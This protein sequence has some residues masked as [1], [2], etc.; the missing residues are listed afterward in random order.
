MEGISVD[1]Q[2]EATKTDKWMKDAFRW[3]R[4][5]RPSIFT[6]L[7]AYNEWIG[8]TLKQFE[9]LEKAR[10]ISKS[11]GC[12]RTAINT[13]LMMNVYFLCCIVHHII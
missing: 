5:E 11:D 7:T 10:R 4:L 8:Q 9:K 6:K 13:L 2:N 3:K 1:I 12:T